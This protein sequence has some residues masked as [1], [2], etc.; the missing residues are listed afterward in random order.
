[1]AKRA[2]A[3]LMLSFLPLSA[4][5][6]STTSTATS[7]TIDHQTHPA[8][9]E[10]AALAKAL[11]PVP[12]YRYED[13]PKAEVA[14]EVAT[15]REGEKKSGQKIFEGM[16]FPSVVADNPALNTARTGSGTKELG[17]LQM[18]SFVETPPAGVEREL[19]VNS[20]GQGKQP[21]DEFEAS[22]VKVFVFVDPTSTNS[23]YH[24]AW[25]RN[26]IF[27]TID[28]VTRANLREWV[29]KYLAIPV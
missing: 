6:A 12:G 2:V 15:L 8:V 26:G 9:G 5:S 25:L 4:C 29:Q 22:G 16:S 13:P 3:I 17:F 21:I 10:T 14:A 24:Y 28:G 1:M 27:G 18:F 11:V 19:A 20:I 23:K 7:T